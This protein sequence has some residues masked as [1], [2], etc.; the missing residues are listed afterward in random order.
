[1]T[2]LSPELL[3]R[4][5]APSPRYTSYPTVTHWGDPPGESEWL[6]HL[7]AAF[8]ATPAVAA[9]YVHIPFCQALCTFCGCHM[10]VVRS[11]ALAGPYV[12]LLRAESALYRPRPRRARLPL[13]ELHLGGGAPNFLPVDDL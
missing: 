9:L 7:D 11:H 5:T 6:A 12:A 1:M 8:G 3:A 13:S 10:R 4:H 2:G